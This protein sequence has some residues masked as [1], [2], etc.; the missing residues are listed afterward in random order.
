[1]KDITI[2]SADQTFCV[3]L[4]FKA[5]HDHPGNIAEYQPDDFF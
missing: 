4:C 1:M 2:R 5:H 3:V